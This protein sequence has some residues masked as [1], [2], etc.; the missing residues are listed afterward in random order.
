LGYR[1]PVLD[2]N[3][4]A[5][6]H[7]TGDVDFRDDLS[8]AQRISQGMVKIHH[9]QKTFTPGSKYSKAGIQRGQ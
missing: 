2:E 9:I 4:T 7:L 6:G 5:V 8:R 1:C 3:L